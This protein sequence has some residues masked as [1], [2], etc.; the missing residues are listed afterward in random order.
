MNGSD[1]TKIIDLEVEKHKTDTN[2]PTVDGSL[3][4]SDAK[5]VI[6]RKRNSGSD[7][8]S[9]NNNLGADITSSSNH[10]MSTS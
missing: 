2:I 7:R 4:V 5:N 8:N 10:R 3:A 9:T 6:S 1:S